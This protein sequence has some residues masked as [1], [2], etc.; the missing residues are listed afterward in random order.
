MHIITSEEKARYTS[1]PISTDPTISD[2]VSMDY[3][4][5]DLCE[6]THECCIFEEKEW[7][8]S[9]IDTSNNSKKNIIFYTYLQEM[10]FG[11]WPILTK[12][13][14]FLQVVLT[15]PLHSSSVFLIWISLVGWYSIDLL[16]SG[17]SVPLLLPVILFVTIT[18]P[19]ADTLLLG[20][21]LCHYA[22]P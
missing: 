16:V 12:I 8:T 19:F 7:S 14:S 15:I 17:T 22:L 5:P 9:D 18:T 13:A 3:I 2:N 1:P 11:R 20:Y 4:T 10:F 21:T 6:H